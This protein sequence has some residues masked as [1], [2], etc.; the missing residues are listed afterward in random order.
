MITISKV[1]LN[2]IKKFKGIHEFS[3]S[4]KNIF[5]ISGKNGSG[6]T[7]IIESLMICQMAFFVN[8]NKDLLEHTEIYNKATEKICSLLSGNYSSISLYMIESESNKEITFTVNIGFI[9]EDYITW[10]LEISNE[11]YNIFAK[12]WDLQNPSCLFFYIDS[13]KYFDEK[14]ITYDSLKIKK[15]DDPDSFLLN[16]IVDYKNVERFAYQKL[17]NDWILQRLV[18]PDVN[19]QLSFLIGR[20]LFSYLLPQLRIQ[21]FT[22]ATGNQFS[23]LAKNIEENSKEFDYRFLSAGEKSIFYLCILINYFSNIGLL[24]IDEPENH[25]HEDLLLRLADTLQQI[26]N[27]NDYPQYIIEKNIYKKKTQKAEE[28]KFDLDTKKVFK[29]YKLQKVIFTTHSKSLI[30]KNFELWRKLCY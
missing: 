16:Y 7:T 15:N 30:Y 12:Y 13:D 1:V 11:D 21:H 22:G 8:S 18:P 29:N 24:I 25:L 3:F 27:C 6:K 26:I 14:S 9:A 23:I 20:I 28:S 2:N 10:S 5:T 4:E 17:I 19:Y